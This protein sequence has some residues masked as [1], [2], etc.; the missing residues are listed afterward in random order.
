MGALDELGPLYDAALT[1]PT[2]EQKKQAMAWGL[3]H[4]GAGIIGAPRGQF[5]RYAGPALAGG[6]DI[7]QGNLKESEKSNK[8]RLSNA[9]NIKKLQKDE[10]TAKAY[11]DI[12][13]PGEE[14]DWLELARVAAQNGDMS[15]VGNALTAHKAANTPHFVPVKSRGYFK[16]DKYTELPGGADVDEPKESDPL[17]RA[18]ELVAQGVPEDTAIALAYGGIRSK[19][20]PDGSTIQENVLP[21]GMKLP[22]RGKMAP[23][24][25]PPGAPGVLA[26]ATRVPVYEDDAP[27]VAPAVPGRPPVTPIVPP[28][29]VGQPPVSRFAPS[30]IPANAVPGTYIPGNKHIVARDK[31]IEDFGAKYQKT[32]IEVMDTHME[33]LL[34]A[35]EKYIDVDEQGNWVPKKNANIPGMGA[36]TKLPMGM[37]SADGKAIRQALK[38]IENQKLY[39]LSGKA[40]TNSE[41]QRQMEAL[42]NVWFSD[43]VSQLRGIQ[44][45]KKAYDATKAALHAS[46]DPEV[47][48]LYRNRKIEEQS[49]IEA[50]FSGQVDKMGYEI[51]DGKK[52]G[53]RFKEMEDGTWRRVR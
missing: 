48:E 30:P 22:P 18:R 14:P 34:G 2:E 50:P 52:T 4:A 40:V 11:A 51:S 43:D 5:L 21:P 7:Y 1:G 31:A 38:D 49:N 20:L 9:L 6:A 3:L 27:P 25:A 32:N 10:K 36:T 23:A 45:V 28:A 46:A 26:P 44:N 35:L 13:K 47:L 33:K 15:T 41:M 29:P 37:L 19:T 8:D 16:G 42:A 12:F 24:A 53:R 39:D 17:K